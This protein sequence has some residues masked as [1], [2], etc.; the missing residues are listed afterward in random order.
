[1]TP[2]STFLTQLFQKMNPLLTLSFLFTALTAQAQSVPFITSGSLKEAQEEAQQ[3]GQIIFVDVYTTWCGPCKMMERQVFADEEVAERMGAFFVN[4]KADAEAGG[5]LVASK[6]NVNAYPTLLFLKPD[7]TLIKRYIGALGKDEFLTAANKALNTS[8]YG[9]A[10]LLYENA[11]DGGNR[12]ADMAAL[13]LK[14]RSAYRM[15]N[16]EQLEQFLQSLPKD[17]LDNPATQ[18]I[19][20]RYTADIKGSAFDYLVERKQVARCANA[21]N[22]IVDEHYKYAV[23]EKSEK[24]LAL[25]VEAAG[26]AALS[27]EA[28]SLRQAQLK[29]Q[30]HL[31]TKRPDLFHAE[32]AAYVPVRL[33]PLLTSEQDSARLQTYSLA[34]ENI[35]WQ[36]AEFVKNKEHLAEALSWLRQCPAPALS[37]ACLRHRSEIAI[38]TER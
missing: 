32:A 23:S 36:Y 14:L 3:T 33:L 1:M 31:E 10:Y 25:T 7:G 30:Y 11:W 19:I 34:L 24:Q 15:G 6:Y 27:P 38:L 13:Y 21:L 17:S 35:A 9:Q 18:K 4:L 5:R 28:A 26:R 37:P 8:A 16:T 12:T 20:A 2:H 29:M 22:R